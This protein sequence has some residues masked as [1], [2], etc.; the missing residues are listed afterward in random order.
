MSKRLQILVPHYKLPQEEMRNLLDMIYIQREVDFDDIGVIIANDGDLSIIDE[1][2]LNHYRQKFNIEYHILPHAGV[3]ATR[4]RLLDLATAEFVMFCDDDD[5]F[6]SNKS[7]NVLIECIKKHSNAN[8]FRSRFK[9][10]FKEDN[11]F[12]L[13]DAGDTEMYSNLHGMMIRRTFLLDN[14]IRFFENI[15]MHEDSIFNIMMTNYLNYDNGEEVMIHSQLYVYCHND[16]SICKSNTDKRLSFVMR[17]TDI[18]INSRYEVFRELVRRNKFNNL[19]QDIVT[20]TIVLTRF[21]YDLEQNISNDEN[22][23]TPIFIHTMLCF[24]RYVEFVKPTLIMVPSQAFESYG[25]MFLSGIELKDINCKDFVFNYINKAEGLSFD[26][27]PLTKWYVDGN[28]G[29]ITY[30]QAD[31]AYYIK[32]ITPTNDTAMT[33]TDLYYCKCDDGVTDA[34]EIEHPEDKPQMNIDDIVKH[35]EENQECDVVKI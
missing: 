34:H 23:I 31:I 9:I 30:S 27:D 18:L 32:N 15:N 28:T 11:M 17:S 35:L 5:T 3:S 10:E 12:V 13:L 19:E 26:N 22:Y 33:L 7:L 25:E 29:V 16:D 24:K 20:Q 1:E 4:N 21:I 2:F 8:V 14:N 6:L